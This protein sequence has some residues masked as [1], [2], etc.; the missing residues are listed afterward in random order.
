M[1][2]V[3][4]VRGPLFQRASTVTTAVHNLK[5]VTTLRAAHIIP[6]GYTTK[7]RDDDGLESPMSPELKDVI[8]NMT[9]TLPI[10]Y[11][12]TG[13]PDR[14]RARLKVSILI[15]PFH[16]LMGWRSSLCGR[17]SFAPLRLCPQSSPL[18]VKRRLK[19]GLG[20]S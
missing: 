16:F 7:S 5:G 9:S 17:L 10:P 18:H 8:Q 6:Y 3:S 2:T 11:P 19:E 12:N 15:L 1:V 4:L 20:K 13:C 14:C